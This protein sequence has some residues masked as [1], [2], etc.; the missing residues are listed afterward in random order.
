MLHW[1]SPTKNRAPGT[2]RN[3]SNTL[4]STFS[5]ATQLDIKYV[6]YVRNDSFEISWLLLKFEK[7]YNTILQKNYIFI[8]FRVLLN[9]FLMY[10]SSLTHR[11]NHFLSYWE[12]RRRKLRYI[13]HTT[14]KDERKTLQNDKQAALNQ[15]C[16]P[17]PF[18]RCTEIN[19]CSVAYEHVKHLITVQ[20]V[21]CRPARV[22]AVSLPLAVLAQWSGSHLFSLAPFITAI[23]EV[24]W[25]SAAGPPLSP[26]PTV[27]RDKQPKLSTQTNC[28]I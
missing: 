24:S 25:L 6:K 19:N 17:R 26:P 13:H 11:C 23:R 21:E 16:W 22:L 2:L 20:H 14:L 28:L 3:P 9:V 12:N 15:T 4:Y 27:D 10:F 7:S 1:W 5:S 8:I 18:H